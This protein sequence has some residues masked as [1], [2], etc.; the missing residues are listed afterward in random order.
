MFTVAINARRCTFDPLCEGKAVIGLHVPD[1]HLAM[2][3][4]ADLLRRMPFCA[5]ESF[6]VTVRIACVVWQSDT[7]LQRVSLL[8]CRPVDALH[9]S[10]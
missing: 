1:A 10:S 2:T 9:E 6:S 7:R 8:G 5:S 4:R 3:L